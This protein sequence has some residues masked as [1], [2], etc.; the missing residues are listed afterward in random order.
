MKQSAFIYVLFIFS[1]IVPRTS[2]A[3]PQSN[4]TILFSN[5]VNGETEPCG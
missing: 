1:L 3:A 4:F 2:G 5:N